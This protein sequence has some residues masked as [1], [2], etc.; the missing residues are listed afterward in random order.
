MKYGFKRSAILFL[1]TTGLLLSGCLKDDLYDKGIIQSTRPNGAT[2]K[3]IELKLTANDASKFLVMSV[4]NSSKDTTM[5]MVPVNLA[6]ADPAPEDLHVSVE[7]DPSLVT[8]YNEKN[9]TDYMVPPSSKY[10]IVSSEVVIP[11]GKHT[12]Y[13]QVKFK[14]ADFLGGPWA[15][16]FKI[17]SIKEEG[18]VISGNLSSGIV[19]IG[20]KNEWD[21]SYA[22][23]GLISGNNSS[24][25][26]QLKGNVSLKTLESN[27]VSEGDIANFFAGYTIYSFNDNGTVDVEAYESA[28]GASY[29]AVVLSS[30]YT[31]STHQFKVKFSILSGKY[32]FDLDYQMK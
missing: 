20:V 23:T 19:S 3:V 32:I 25:G 22:F 11:K 1:A 17:T 31:Q 4:P 13:L 24:S 29:D 9:E 18:Y 6:T 8:T 2:P 27:S 21:G 30:S 16:G 5:D 12:G 7:L 14:S 26:T 10:S 15:L 28:G